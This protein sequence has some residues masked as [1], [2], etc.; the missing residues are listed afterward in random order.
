[1]IRK[2]VSLKWNNFLTNDWTFELGTHKHT[3]SPLTLLVYNA[4]IGRSA[5]HIEF[6]DIIFRY[7]ISVKV[8][9]D[10]GNPITS[11]FQAFFSAVLSARWNENIEHSTERKELLS[12]MILALRKLTVTTVSG[13]Q[14]TRRS[15]YH[16]RGRLTVINNSIEILRSLNFNWK[17]FCLHFGQH[18]PCC[19]GK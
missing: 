10:N 12:A 18:P 13:R 3:T 1:M 8:T 6:S 14:Q 2:H 16:S 19:H 15:G 7:S 9:E 4:T 11:L 5:G 17:N